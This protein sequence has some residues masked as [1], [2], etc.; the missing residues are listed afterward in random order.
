MAVGLMAAFL[1]LRVAGLDH[2]THL[3]VVLT[4]VVGAAL[5]LGSGPGSTAVVVGGGVSTAAS[6]I[7]VDNVFQTPHAYVQ[8]L[9]Y[10][11][12]ATALVMLVRIA[13]RPRPLPAGPLTGLP[14][15]VT[16]P[17]PIEP[18]TLREREVLRLAATGI[19]VDEIAGR[20]F[21][22]PNTVKTHLTHVY[23]KLGV[24]GR[25]DAVRAALH[26]GCLT[27]AD[28]CPHSFGD[29]TVEAPVSVTP[30]HRKG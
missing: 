9:A 2:G 24:R 30:E 25:S 4:L 17:A 27:P 14:R 29:A 1:E 23:A 19:K 21:L 13:R 16:G 22:S 28:I 18:L 6:V 26:S 8:L 20:L 3:L 11:V 15:L 5:L 7:S 10:L 12:S